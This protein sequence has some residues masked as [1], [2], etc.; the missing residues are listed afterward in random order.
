[1][2]FTLQMAYFLSRG[3]K[4]KKETCPAN[5]ILS[6]LLLNWKSCFSQNFNSNKPIKIAGRTQQPLSRG[7]N[8]CV[9]I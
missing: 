8:A 5:K 4:T 6:Y 9:D 2:S 7:G 3:K 1:M